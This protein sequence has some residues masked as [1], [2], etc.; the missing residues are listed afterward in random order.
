MVRTSDRRH[1]AQARKA[2]SLASQL[3]A[4]RSAHAETARELDALRAQ[5]RE[6]C[7]S[8][9]A[10]AVAMLG[11]GGESGGLVASA[12]SDKSAEARIAELAAE[13]AHRTALEAALAVT[14]ETEGIEYGLEVGQRGADRADAPGPGRCHQGGR[15][16]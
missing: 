6:A 16:P 2:R 9:P 8:D 14:M 3:V 12:V 1:R 15:E 4:E 13:R 7:R 11:M 5:M 10:V